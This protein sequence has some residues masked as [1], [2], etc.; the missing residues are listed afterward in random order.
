M[1]PMRKVAAYEAKRRQLLELQLRQSG[2][3][4]AAEENVDGDSFRKRDSDG[5]TLDDER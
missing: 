2:F 3:F 1:R 5:H 4:D